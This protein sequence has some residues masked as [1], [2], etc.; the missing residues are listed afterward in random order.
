MSAPKID[1]KDCSPEVRKQLLSAAGECE[2][3]KARTFTIDRVLLLVLGS[4]LAPVRPESEIMDIVL[5]GGA[6]YEHQ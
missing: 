3:R 2:P 6:D 1:L 4:S 5:G